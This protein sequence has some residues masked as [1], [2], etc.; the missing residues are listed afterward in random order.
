MNILNFINVMYRFLYI[1]FGRFRFSNCDLPILIVTDRFKSNH[2]SVYQSI[3]YENSHIKLKLYI[4]EQHIYDINHEF[5]LV[6]YLRFPFKLLPICA[7]LIWLLKQWFY[8]Q[9]FY[10]LIHMRI[11]S[12]NQNSFNVKGSASDWLSSASILVISKDTTN[13]FSR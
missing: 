9:W 11:L 10:S 12:R 3:S 4:C 6:N 5:H 8:K 2:W 1:F 13:T 7:K